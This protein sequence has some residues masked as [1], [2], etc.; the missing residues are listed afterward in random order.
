MATSQSTTTVEQT[1][2]SEETSGVTTIDTADLGNS[3]NNKIEEEEGQ[4]QAYNPE[5]G[6]INWDCPCLGG[7]AQGTCGEEFKAA[8]S[9]FIY[10]EE[11]PKGMD[12]VDAF[13]AMQD[14]FR[15]HPEEYANEI[16]DGEEDDDIETE[17]SGNDTDIEDIKDTEN[18]D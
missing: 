3:N 15:A 6:E 2:S 18:K 12:C 13:K 14:C 11:E 4:S 7:M 1:I 16:D 10:S 9:C 5:T 17:D 8:F